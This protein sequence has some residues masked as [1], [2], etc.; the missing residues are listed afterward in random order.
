MQD[1]TI[2]LISQQ[3]VI[4]EIGNQILQEN[5]VEVPIT[6]IQDVYQSEFYNASQQGLKP[7]LRVVINNLNYNDEE[8]L[9]YMNKRYTIIRVDRVDNEYIALVCEK[10]V[11]YNGN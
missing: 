3:Y 6:E 5:L 9:Y 10:R 8:E 1:W 4:D 11:G 7:T 2:K